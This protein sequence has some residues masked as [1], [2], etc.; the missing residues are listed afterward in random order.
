MNGMLNIWYQVGVFKTKSFRERKLFGWL[1]GFE[2]A[3]PRTT[4]WCSNQL[5]YNHHGERKNNDLRS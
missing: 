3:T 2:P 5:S 4:I 1:T